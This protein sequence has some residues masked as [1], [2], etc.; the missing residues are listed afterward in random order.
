MISSPLHRLQ[1]SNLMIPSLVPLHSRISPILYPHLARL[2]WVEMPLVYLE[3]VGQLTYV[4][5]ELLEGEEG[6]GYLHLMEVEEAVVAVVAVEEA[7]SWISSFWARD[8]KPR[9]CVAKKV[10]VFVLTVSFYDRLI[11]NS[12][13]N[14]ATFS[15]SISGRFC[16]YS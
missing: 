11:H 7:P 12:Q 6:M 15:F 9:S 5:S 13:A 4:Q 2:C 14:F 3:V 1:V 8:F 16:F 10:S